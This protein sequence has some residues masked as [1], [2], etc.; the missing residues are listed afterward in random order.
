MPIHLY[1]SKKAQRYIDEQV[2]DD[3]P[4]VEKQ[5][6]PLTLWYVDVFFIQR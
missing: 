2:Y 6:D 4:W 5:V 3:L 1:Q